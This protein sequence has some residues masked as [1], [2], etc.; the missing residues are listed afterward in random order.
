MENREVATAS[1]LRSVTEMARTLG[2]RVVAEGIE[3]DTQHHLLRELAC[4]LGQGY[5][6]SR[7]LAPEYLLAF[8]AQRAEAQAA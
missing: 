1:L 7:P 8:C 2:K 3:T 5:R 6:F 4:E